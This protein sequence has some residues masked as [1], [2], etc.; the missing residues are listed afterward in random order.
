MN[1]SLLVCVCTLNFLFN[2][3]QKYNEQEEQ[4]ILYIDKKKKTFSL[5]QLVRL[6]S[7]K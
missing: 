3:I 6:N 5:M 1:V 4:D 2:A 7:F